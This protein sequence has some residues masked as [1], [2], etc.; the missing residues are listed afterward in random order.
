MAASFS[1]KYIDGFADDIA[2]ITGAFLDKV[3]G[4]HNVGND[5]MTLTLS[6]VLELLFGSDRLNILMLSENLR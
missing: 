5:C 4:T 2:R 1:P 3:D 6:I